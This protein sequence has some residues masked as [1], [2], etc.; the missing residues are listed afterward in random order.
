MILVGAAVF[1][2]NLGLGAMGSTEL[3]KELVKA[4]ISCDL[5]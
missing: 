1:G 5:L 3:G 2:I 4:V